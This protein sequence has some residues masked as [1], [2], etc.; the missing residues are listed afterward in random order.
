MSAV[1]SGGRVRVLVVDDSAT[2]RGMISVVLQDDP[3]IDVV[4]MAGDPHEARQMIKMLAP[5]VITLDIEMPNMDGLEFL[6]K[7]MRLRPTPVV[8]VSSLTQAGADA[9]L[10]ALEI[11]AFDCV[12]KPSAFNQHSFDQLAEKVKAA[13]RSKPRP[14]HM[15]AAL[16]RSGQTAAVA[17]QSGPAF[18]PDG[19]IVAIGSST[20]GVEALIA[21]LTKF[22]VNCP[23]T[24]ISQHMPPQFTKSFAERLNK[25]CH[26]AVTE[27]VDGAVLKVGQ[28][29]L[30]PGS[31]HLEITTGAAPRIRL[32]EAERVNGHRPSVDVMFA[33]VLRSL[34]ARVIG[35]ILTGL[36]RDGA[37]G[38]LALREAGAET[39]GQD[40]A[41]S[42][43]YG[44]PKVA[45]EIGAVVRQL[46]LE[47]IAERILLSA[48]ANRREPVA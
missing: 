25:L 22:P 41:S 44:M 15:R 10:R 20:G 13:A 32:S 14:G 17:P 5:D 38:L 46:P 40:E 19:R 7:I 37:D 43:V 31:H 26:P 48:N 12:S 8:M 6:D 24:I 29:Y 33:S 21:I 45:H 34:G 4:G 28:I 42:V 16:S 2:M 35:V 30:S 1:L 3:A 39:I 27:A 18:K 9:S 23:P 36:G 47:R 11:G